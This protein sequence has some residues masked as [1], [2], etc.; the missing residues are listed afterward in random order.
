MEL[1]VQDRIRNGVEYDLEQLRSEL[2]LS[3]CERPIRSPPKMYSQS[4]VSLRPHITLIE[5]V[6]KYLFAIRIRCW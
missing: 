5:S 6:K 3:L 4:T 1:I 2:Y